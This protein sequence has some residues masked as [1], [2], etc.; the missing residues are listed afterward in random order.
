VLEF[1]VAVMSQKSLA[2]SDAGAGFRCHIAICWYSVN[3]IRI[4]FA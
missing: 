2:G 1:F 3:V 4:G